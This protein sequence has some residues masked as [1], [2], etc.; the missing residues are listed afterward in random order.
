MNEAEGRGARW[1]WSKMICP[2]DTEKLREQI[3][4]LTPCYFGTDNPSFKC[5]F[6]VFTKDCLK[7]ERR[8]R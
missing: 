5:L 8:E 3:G 6:N 2:D 4:I 1:S 7:G